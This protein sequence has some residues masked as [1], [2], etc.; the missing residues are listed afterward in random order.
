MDS[1]DSINRSLGCSV[2][3]AWEERIWLDRREIASSLSTSRSGVLA[4]IG[5]WLSRF[6]SRSQLGPAAQGSGL[7]GDD[8]EKR[9]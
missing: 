1:T 6:R 8:P 3:S 7:V 9:F 5:A 4:R 2:V